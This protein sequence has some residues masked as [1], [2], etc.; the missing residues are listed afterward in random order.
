MNQIR[1]LEK[2]CQVMEH[3][4]SSNQNSLEVGLRAYQPKFCNRNNED[5]HISQNNDELDSLTYFRT[6]HNIK[7]YLIN[8]FK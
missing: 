4:V 2:S 5:E 1:F 6:S 8:D 7:L 3:N